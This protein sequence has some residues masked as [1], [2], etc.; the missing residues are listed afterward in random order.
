MSENLDLVRSICTAWGR[1]DFSSNDWAD[2]RIEVVVGDGPEQGRWH[3]RDG[4]EA[5]WRGFLGAWGDYRVEVDQ[6]RELDSERVLI[7]M[8]HGGYGRASGLGDKQLTTEGANVF[9]MRDG[10]VV[11]LLLYWHRDRALADLGLE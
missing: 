9:Q 7:L 6:F 1:G 4:M 8:R 10:K 2:E 5:G 3:G 11:R